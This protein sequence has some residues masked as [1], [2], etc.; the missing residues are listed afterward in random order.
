MR[1]HILVHAY[2]T[3]A[4]VFKALIEEAMQT[5][6]DVIWSAILPTGN[7]L[8]MMTNLLG[9]ENIC[10]LHECLK[11]T[12]RE[13]FSDGHLSDYYGNVF[14]DLEA[15]QDSLKFKPSRRK[16]INAK[17][18]YKIYKEFLQKVKPT[19]VFFAHCETHEALILDRVAREL[20][21]QPIHSVHT[22]NVGRT[23]FSSSIWEELPPYVEISDRNREEASAY[24]ERFNNSFVSPMTSDRDELNGLTL[25]PWNHPSFPQRVLSFFKRFFKESENESFR[26][27]CHRINQNLPLVRDLAR[28]LR[29]LKN[30]KI[31]TIRRMEDL[32][33]KFIFYPYQ[34]TPESSINIPAPYLVDQR[35]VVDLIR[36]NMPGDYTLVIK[37][38]PQGILTRP[39]QVFKEIHLKAGVEICDYRMNTTELTKR[40][41]LT[42]SVTGTAAF[43]AFLRRKRSLVFA[44][45]FFAEFLGGPCSIDKAGAHIQARLSKEISDHEVR[46]AVAKIYAA[47]KPFLV[48]PPEA[49]VGGRKTMSRENIRLFLSSL[50]DHVQKMRS[51]F[52]DRQKLSNPVLDM[53]A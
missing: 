22:R 3:F 14:R 17:A 34:V 16:T 33:K 32:P 43:E 4:H 27:F 10:Y 38:H 7:H 25:I 13:E 37:E 31:C 47:S 30:Q 20:R 35:R 24:I 36:F 51:Y 46:E 8:E 12:M 19:H 6:P 5:R 44:G 52:D 23:F 39:G 9:R 50:L 40:A 53:D 29:V 49:G 1:P 45:T 48:L 18:T 41:A 15:D 21:I 2:G 11:S 28:S 42:I 26:G